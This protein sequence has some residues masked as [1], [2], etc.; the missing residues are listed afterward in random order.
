MKQNNRIST[1]MNAEFTEGIREITDALDKIYCILMEMIDEYDDEDRKSSGKEGVDAVIA[2]AIN[3]EKEPVKIPIYGLSE[4]DFSGDDHEAIFEI[5]GTDLVITCDDR[6]LIEIGGHLYLHGSGF[7][8][9]LDK[10][11]DLKALD[12]DDWVKAMNYLSCV[13]RTLLCGSAKKDVYRLKGSVK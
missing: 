11:A 3:T 13:K 12:E 6:D 5:S 9:S 8:V 7:I 4:W 2:V 1:C 10:E